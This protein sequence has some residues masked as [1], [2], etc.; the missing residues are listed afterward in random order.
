MAPET[1]H[2]RADHVAV[3]R[4]CHS[5]SRLEDDLITI[6]SALGSAARGDRGARCDAVSRAWIGV[7]ARLAFALPP[8][9]RARAPAPPAD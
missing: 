8:L 6:V 9:Q 4:S 1:R 3:C 7:A 5:G 2:S